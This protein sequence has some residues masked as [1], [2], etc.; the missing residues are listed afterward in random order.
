MVYVGIDAAKD[1]HDCCILGGNGQTVQ[2][3]FTFRN[4]HEGFEQLISA[5]QRSS[6][7][8]GSGQ[9]RAG[10]ESTGHYSGNLEAFLRSSG[11]ELVVFNPLQVN[12]YR[13]SL[14]L[15][16]TKTDKVDAKYIAQLLITA[17]SNP[18]SVSY[19]IQELKALTRHR[20]RL[21]SQRTKLKISISRLVV[22]LFPELPTICTSVTQAAIK[23]L[24]LELPGARQIAACRIDRLTNL[25]RAASKGRYGRTKAE[26]IKSLAQQSIGANSPATSLEL[27]LTLQHLDFL[28]KQI[29]QLDKA[30]RTAVTQIQTPILSIPGIGPTLAGIIL[31]EIGDIHR[32]SSPDKLQ[33]F[34]GLD[35]STYQSGKF[36]ADRTP[37]VKHG[38]TYLRWALMQ[39]ARLATVHCETFSRYQAAKQAQGKHYFVALGHTAKKLIR[40][41]FH[42]L[43]TNEVFVPQT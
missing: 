24:L 16:K 39:A 7:A 33:A 36:N 34:A 38:S 3:A 29:N 25:L 15:R 22:I 37:M 20:F 35:P 26:E 4:N 43:N 6:E 30:I 13:K 8:E 1:K 5:I 2:E 12:L 40:V 9:I 32:F 28:Q 11:V 27:Q 14:T 17:E 19:Q 23:T 10:L 21:V 18:V 42:I 41:I 31:A